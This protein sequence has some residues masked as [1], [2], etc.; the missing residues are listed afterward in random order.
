MIKQ[1][2]H[3]VRLTFIRPCLPPSQHFGQ[4]Q[5]LAR[6][7]LTVPSCE[8][9]GNISARQAGWTISQQMPHS[10]RETEGEGSFIAF[11]STPSTPL[12]M[13]QTAVW[14]RRGWNKETTFTHHTFALHNGVTHWMWATTLALDCSHFVFVIF[15]RNVFPHTCCFLV[16][17]SMLSFDRIAWNLARCVLIVCSWQRSCYFLDIHYFLEN[18]L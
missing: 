6:S 17:L 15:L 14:A 10:M 11:C 12:Q 2:R 8:R 18:E 5:L 9:S 16:H 4:S 3:I 1:S 13:R 7:S